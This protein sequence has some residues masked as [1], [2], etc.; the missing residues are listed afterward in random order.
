VACLQ[1][2]NFLRFAFP[3]ALCLFSPARSRWSASLFFTNV[4][5]GY[6]VATSIF[7]VL[8]AV[9]TRGLS[10]HMNDHPSIS[11]QASIQPNLI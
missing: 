9:W 3:V 11:I 5:C 8:P 1:S 7:L 2:S 6:S 4:A 10:I